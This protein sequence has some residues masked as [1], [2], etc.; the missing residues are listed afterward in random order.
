MN[1]WYTLH[2]FYFVIDIWCS[3]EGD[4]GIGSGENEDEQRI[5]SNEPL[6]EQVWVLYT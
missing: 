1:V 3:G 6:R 5:E 2:K 4:E